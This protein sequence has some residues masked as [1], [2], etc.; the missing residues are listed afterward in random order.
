MSLV[1]QSC[2]LIMV[3]YA[4][5]VRSVHWSGRMAGLAWCLM[6]FSVSDPSSQWT[7]LGFGHLTW[8]MAGRGR[9]PNFLSSVQNEQI[10]MGVPRA[11]CVIDLQNG[12][13]TCEW[14]GSASRWRVRLIQLQCCL[15][16][17]PLNLDCS[18]VKWVERHPPHG[19]VG[20]IKWDD[21]CEALNTSGPLTSAWIYAVNG[22]G[23]SAPH[24]KAPGDPSP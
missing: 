3:N 24:L 17:R 20:R 11:S 6:Y 19:A 15:L 9:G 14:R 2:W 13:G 23:I 18:S 1:T 8:V 10:W 7:G 21:A 5:A 4:L 12:E 16:L 22:P